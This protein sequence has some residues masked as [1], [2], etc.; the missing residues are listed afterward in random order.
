MPDIGSWLRRG[1]CRLVGIDPNLLPNAGAPPV[2]RPP[3]A[4]QPRSHFAYLGND[5]GI[6]VLHD[7]SRIFVDT[8][9]LS[10]TPSLIVYGCWEPWIETALLRLVSP[11]AVVVDL[12]AN[13]GYYTLFLA[14]AVG[15]KGKVFAFEANPHLIDLLSATIIA[16]GLGARVVVKNAAIVDREDTVELHVDPRYCGGGHLAFGPEESELQHYR[17]KGTTLCNALADIERIDVLRMD[18]EG[19]EPLALHGAEQLIRN[20]PELIIICEW[21]LPMLVAHGDVPALVSW[22]TELGFSFWE[23]RTDSTLRPVPRE[24]MLTIGHCDVVISRQY[25]QNLRRQQ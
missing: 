24:E 17:V 9:D 5:R 21:S 23:I 13:F 12:G 11:G 10:L 1:V 20:S 18:I 4:P 8:R 22:L 6:V 25:P 19:S 7:G 15:P 14:R 2:A 3:L 16:N